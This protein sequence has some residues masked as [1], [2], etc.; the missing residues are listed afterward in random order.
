VHFGW[1]R[2]GS[3]APEH[4]PQGWQGQLHN[5]HF[6]CFHPLRDVVAA[7]FWLTQTQEAN[8]TYVHAAANAA[9]G[10]FN[11]T[12]VPRGR[13]LFFAGALPAVPRGPVLP[14]G[15]AGH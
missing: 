15:P 14:A 6:G 11:A 1:H 8:A 2:V 4:L 13:L 12:E 7:P 3:T 5:P 10:G 9:S